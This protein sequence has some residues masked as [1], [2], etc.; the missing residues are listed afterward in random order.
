MQIENEGIFQHSLTNG[1]NLF[2]GSG[3]SVFAKDLNLKPLPTGRALALELADVFGLGELGSLDLPQVC[4]IIEHTQKDKL[5][6]YLENRFTV[7]EF[8]DRYFILDRINVKTIFTTNIDDLIF[9]VYSRSSS[10]YLNDLDVRGASFNDRNA[11]DL[12]TFHG[13]VA[14]PIRPFR[15]GTVDIAASFAS[16]PDR[17]YTLTQNFQKT[18]TLF[19]GYS[20]GDAG[21]LQALHPSSV[22]GRAYKD[23]WIVLHPSS[24]SSGSLNFFKALKLQIIVA[25][26]SEMLDYLSNLSVLADRSNNVSTDETF[27]NLFHR[28]RIPAVGTVPVRP[29]IEFFQGAAP[30]WSDI[31]SGQLHQTEHATSLRNVI[32]SGNHALVIGI[33]ASG[34]T[35]LLMQVATNLDIDSYIFWMP[36]LTPERAKLLGTSLGGAKALVFVDNFTDSIEGFITLIPFSNILLVG[37]DRDYNFEIVSDKIDRKLFTILSVTDLSPV[38][39]QACLDTLPES[40]ARRGEVRDAMNPDFQPSLFEIIE[41]N[42]KVP[43][44]KERYLSALIQ[45]ERENP[46]FRDILLMICYCYRCRVPVSMDMMLS[47]LRGDINGYNE[48]YSILTKVGEMITDYEGG[49]MEDAQDYWIARSAIV[50]EAV[51]SKAQQH[52]LRSMLIR[53]HNNVSPFRICRYDVFKR[54]AFD[55]RLIG[56]AFPDADQGKQF[57]E[58]VFARDGSAYSLQ[59]AALYLSNKKRHTE[60]FEMIDRAINE[61]GGHIWSIRNSHAIILFRANYDKA[62]DP[63]ARRQ[64]EQSMNILTECIKADRRKPFHVLTFA[65]QALKFSR[66]YGDRQ[67]KEYLS[68]AEKWLNDE[69]RRS[70]WNKEVA[71]L[72][73]VIK[74][75][76]SKLK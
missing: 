10:H 54:Y 14:N 18:P 68:A 39:I 44:L 17:W 8:D 48:V 45:L 9:K 74:G 32:H 24:A 33:P 38:D 75:A 11:I 25:D 59:H 6:D 16:D 19:W 28:D 64:L 66:V 50:G 52:A 5:R 72:L 47:Y 73:P 35:T 21:T 26:T 70:P 40:A 63:F 23:M 69:R 53:F 55:N 30:E 61:S 62:Q 13:S 3:F 29:I 56:R 67:S 42:L 15:F 31:F 2:L 58:D 51:I 57:Y 34:K 22:H 12:V 7:S 49:M 37:A 65:D 20:L 41:V 43:T 27:L 60:A 36:S 1:I 71:R 46:L 76:I 4:T